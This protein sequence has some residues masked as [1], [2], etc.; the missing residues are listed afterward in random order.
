MKNQESDEKAG[1]EEAAGDE[2]T[3]DEAEEDARRMARRGDKVT[4]TTAQ[5]G[6]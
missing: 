2:E 6:Q 5:S 4:A 3:A 1:M